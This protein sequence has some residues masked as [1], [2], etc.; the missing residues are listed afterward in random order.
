[1]YP[2]EDPVETPFDPV[3]VF[4]CHSRCRGIPARR[5]WAQGA[6]RGT[7]ELARLPGHT[8]GSRQRGN[9]V[10]VRPVLC[11]SGLAASYRGDAATR[12]VLRQSE[13]GRRHSCDCLAQATRTLV[14]G[15]QG[16]GNSASRWSKSTPCPEC[17]MESAALG[18]GLLAFLSYVITMD[19]PNPHAVHWITSRAAAVTGFA[20]GLAIWTPQPTVTV[21]PGRDGT[22][23]KSRNRS[24][25]RRKVH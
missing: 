18:A 24:R 20:I 15:G 12:L 16:G 25:A 3:V 11:R 2:F 21:V 10:G 9:P 19:H 1:M 6:L 13:P 8:P 7:E 23:S 4:R 5:A 22:G 17:H 14:N